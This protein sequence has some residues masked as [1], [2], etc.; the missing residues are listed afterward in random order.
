MKT[1]RIENG[2]IPISEIVFVTDIV[3]ISGSLLFSVVS[4]DG[5]HYTASSV[6]VGGGGLTLMKIIS[7]RPKDF[8]EFSD[9]REK[10]IKELNA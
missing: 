6:H 2:D 9:I 4:R 7:E 5:N 3:F 1:I 8:K 10:F